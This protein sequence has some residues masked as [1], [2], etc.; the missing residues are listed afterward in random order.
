MTTR[1]D[2]GERR[3]RSHL[4]NDLHADVSKQATPISTA[5]AG[6]KFGA[7]AMRTQFAF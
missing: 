5:N 6:S 7:V 4:L 2:P 3:A 1:C